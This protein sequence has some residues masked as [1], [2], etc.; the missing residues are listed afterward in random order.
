MLKEA[1]VDII[2]SGHVHIAYTHILEGIIISHSGTT[3]S[4]RL[5]TDSPNSFNIIDGNRRELTIKTREWKHG[6]FQPAGSQLFFRG[7]NGWSE[8]SSTRSTYDKR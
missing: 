8:T 3:L 6:A 1:G 4:D 7:Q 2:L 5:M